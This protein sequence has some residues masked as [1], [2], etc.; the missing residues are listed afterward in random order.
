MRSHVLLLVLGE[1][2]E[3]RVHAAVIWPGCSIASRAATD[4]AMS[5]TTGAAMARL[6][7]ISVGGMSSWTNC[8]V[9]DHCGLLPWPSSQFSRAPISITTSACARANERAAAADCGWSSGSRPLAMDM[10]RKGIPV[11]STKARMSASACAYAAPLPRMI[12]GR[13]RSGQ[14]VQGALTASGAGSCRGAGSTTRTS[15][16]APGLGVERGGQHAGREIEIHAARTAGDGGADGARQTDADV[17]GAVDA[18]RRLRVRLGRVHLV[19][20]LVVAL[21]EV[22]DRPVARPA[23][24]DHREAVRRGVGQRH[25]AVEEAGR[26][27][28]EADARFLRQEARCGRRVAGG[29][30][31]AEADVAHALACA[32]RARS[33]TGCRPRRRWC[34]GR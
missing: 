11:F 3:P 19:E 17:L 16:R 24:L 18:V 7:S 9:G 21:L 6:L 23:D 30:L 15:D 12:S 29:L 2:I 14:Q 25:H 20:L 33:V 27:D 8:A 26:R 13:S 28:G 32:G 4:E 34:R 22:D 10:G 1:R 31:V 5:P